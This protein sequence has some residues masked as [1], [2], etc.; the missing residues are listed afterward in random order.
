MTRR[1]ALA[2]GLL[3]LVGPLGAG[4]DGGTATGEVAGDAPLPAA[5]RPNIVLI[6]IDTLR[7]DHLGLFG[8]E[9]ETAPFVRELAER[10]VVFRNA[11]SSSSWTAPSTASV[12]T[13]L[14]APKHGIKEGFW[15]HKKNQENEHDTDGGDEADLDETT[16]HINSIPAYLTT[17]PQRLQAEGYQTL[18]VASNLNIGK[19]IGFSRGFDEFFKNKHASAD[20]LVDTLLEWSASLDESRPYFMYMHVN[21]A[22]MPYKEQAPWYQAQGDEL[23][24]E[25]A[26]YD[27]E[28]SYL[29]QALRRV[30]DELDWGEDAVVILISDHG[31]EFMDRGKMGHTFSLYAELNHVLT[32]VSD[33]AARDRARDVTL[34]TSLVDVFPTV[35]EYA[36]V[37]PGEGVDGHSLVPLVRGTDPARQALFDGRRV[38]AFRGKEAR[39]DALWAVVD[40]N[41]KLIEND[42]SGAVELFDL[43]ADPGEQE[44]LAGSRPERLASLREVLAAFRESAKA[45]DPTTVEVELDDELY[46]DLKS[47]GYT[48]GD[49][50]GELPQDPDH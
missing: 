28:I 37:D 6:L 4:C 39:P 17:L 34:R 38:F 15:A 45:P 41:W 26:R 9:R 47:L 35:L 27:S 32:I 13:G 40:G 3:A 42:A 22:H 31:E 20:R 16:L 23:R 29:D 44:N 24:D 49:D 43:A 1:T 21:D 33:P 11:H 7:V 8:Y 14:Y 36:Q 10:S 5:G 50:E 30:H 25:I 19:R 12:F 48:G 18:G 2:A 46:E